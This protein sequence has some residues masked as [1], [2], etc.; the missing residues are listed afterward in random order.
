VYGRWIACVVVLTLSGCVHDPAFIT[1]SERPHP[2]VSVPYDVVHLGCSGIVDRR[3]RGRIGQPYCT[4]EARWIWQDDIGTVVEVAFVVTN[5]LDYY[6][7]FASICENDNKRLRAA[8]LT[9]HIKIPDDCNSVM[10]AVIQQEQID[11][12]NARR[13]E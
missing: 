4:K 7:M 1:V 3:Y 12:D 2:L 10:R 11:R 13:G 6:P 9:Q 8:L 5:L